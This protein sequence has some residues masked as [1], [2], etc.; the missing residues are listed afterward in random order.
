MAR[1][2]TIERDHVFD[3]RVQIIAS[4]ASS[5]QYLEPL[6]NGGFMV[7]WPEENRSHDLYLRKYDE[8]MSLRVTLIFAALFSVRSTKLLWWNIH[9]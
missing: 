7:L 2:F 5:H 6:S 1:M 8:W 9:Y 3:C 4:R